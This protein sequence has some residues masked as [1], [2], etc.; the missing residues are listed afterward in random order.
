M[1]SRFINDA[2]VEYKIFILP[3]DAV[4]KLIWYEVGISSV[5]QIH[6]PM[7]ALFLCFSIL[8]AIL[9]VREFKNSLSVAVLKLILLA[10]TANIIM[11]AIVTVNSMRVN[12]FCIFCIK[13]LVKY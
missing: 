5:G 9:F 8:D 2:P 6:L 3:L 1:L 10:P 7:R 13:K 12:H 4:E 11:I